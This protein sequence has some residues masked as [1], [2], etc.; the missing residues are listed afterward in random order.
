MKKSPAVTFLIYGAITHVSTSLLSF[1]VSLASEWMAVAANILLTYLVVPV[2][3][4]LALRAVYKEENG[5]KSAGPAFGGAGIFLA[6]QVLMG[7]IFYII[8]SAKYGLQLGDWFAYMLPFIFL[9]FV[10][11][12]AAMCIYAQWRLFKKAGKPGWAS[13]VPVYNLVVQ[14]EIAR[15]P[16][17]W[18]AMFFLPIVSIVFAIMLLNKFVQAYGKDAGFTVGMIFLPL[19]FMPILGFGDSRYVYGDNHNNPNQFNPAGG[20][21]P[22]QGNNWQQ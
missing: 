22:P 10:I 12:L 4:I 6:L 3:F 2:I 19:I 21:Y 16:M 7:V 5:V 11:Y 1:L 20:P 14:C 13:I 9:S 17:W 18:I 8:Q 15:V